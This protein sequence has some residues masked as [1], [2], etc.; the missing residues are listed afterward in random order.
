MPPER[1]APAV[2]R[3][4]PGLLDRR[5]VA[6]WAYDWA[7]SAP[8]AIIISF[9]F[10]TYFVEGVASG[11]EV[12]SALW[13]N[14]IALSGV[15]IALASVLLGPVAD[16]GAG[17]KRWLVI[18]SG[19][20]ILAG[21]A[22]WWV[23]PDPGMV[24]LGLVLAFLVN[25]GLEV[26]MVFYNAMLPRL[27][28]PDRLGRVSGWG[29][30]I[31]YLGALV[32]LA[33][34]LALVLSEPPP[35]GLDDAQA[36]PVRLT[37]VLASAWFLVFM[38]PLVFLYR[39]PPPS[40]GTLTAMRQGLASVR[41]TL[42][43]VRRHRA[44][45]RFLIAHTL[46]R[47]GVNT[48]FFFGGIYA[49]GTFA[50]TTEEVLAF[51]IAIYVSAGIGAFAFAWADDRFGARPVVLVAIAGMIVLAV[52]L[53]VVEGKLWFFVFGVPLGLFFGPVQAS[54]R[55]LMARLVPPGLE[56]RAFGLFGLS[57][58]AISPFGPLIVGWVTLLADSQRVGMATILIFLV[59]GGLLLATLREPSP[60]SRS[61]G[62]P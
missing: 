52:P 24:A 11:T 7:S 55:S 45:T 30:G 40:I 38:L 4:R 58:K 26:A 21:F 12:G 42:R 36:E 22:L 59:A 18:F 31:G 23:V 1:P 5:I 33:L 60:G 17:A 19:L 29:W 48:L 39:E 10:A 49:A 8:P 34:A 28:P 41:E 6:W 3:P 54:S 56:G 44:M 14:M 53:I 15:T 9:V 2:P 50:M 27:A 61:V 13:G 16:E 62:P 37:A 51:G 35:F 25:V 43:L 57:G 46:Y 32:C 47:D 20:A